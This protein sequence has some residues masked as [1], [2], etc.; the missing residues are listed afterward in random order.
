MSRIIVKNIP[1]KIT[2]DEIKKHFSLKGDVTDVKVMKSKS[3]MSRKFAFIGLK[4]EI[5]AQNCIKYF[6]HTYFKTNKIE[7]EAAKVQGDSS[8][9]KPWSKHSTWVDK[10]DSK[11]VN[12]KN[13]SKS[14]EGN[15][16]NKLLSKESKESKISKLMEISKLTSTKS[17]FDEIGK[18]IVDGKLTTGP[19]KNGKEL[20]KNNEDSNTNEAENNTTNNTTNDYS[21]LL[22][23]DA[24][25][26]YIRNLPFE[27][28]STDLRPLFEKYGEVTEIHVP[29]NFKTN[30]SFGYGYVSYSTLESTVMALG[31]LDKSIFQGR[32]I[33]I[34][35]A[36]IK[37]EVMSLQAL[38][39]KKKQGQKS[40]YKNKKDQQLID[41]YANESNWNYL[42]INQN[43]AIEAIAQ[44]L[45][46]PKAEILSVDNSNL[47]VQVSAMETIIINETKKWLEEVGINLNVFKGS[48]QNCERSKTT[49]LIKNIAFSVKKTEL[50]KMFSHYGMMSRFLL[51]P[52]NTLGIAEF[53]DEKHAENCIKNCS[54]YEVEGLPLYLEYAP[55]GLIATKKEKEK[56]KLEK[57]KEKEN[58][59]VVEKIDL[60]NNT[61]KIVFVSNLNFITSDDDLKNL[62]ANNGFNVVE[63]KIATHKKGGNTLSSGYGF[64]ELATEK[65]AT[66]IIKTMQGSI[67]DEH[68]LKLS[69]AKSKTDK[70]TKL[71]GNKRHSENHGD[72]DY[73]GEDIENTK[74]LVKN[75]AFE[76][77]RQELRELFK[78]YGEVKSVRFPTKIDGTHRGFAFVDFVSH[79][80]AKNVFI[81][82]QNTH[83]YGR[84]LVFEWAEK[85]KSLEELR[86]QTERKMKINSIETHRTQVKSKLDFKKDNK[87]SKKDK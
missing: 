48:R 77:N 8:L 31:E 21:D 59:G 64:I 17:K 52:S 37:K 22:K 65:E 54:Y 6:N 45:N 40:E 83:F 43:A 30:Q 63:A 39:N 15:K 27:C 10:T 16:D 53:I 29:K 55:E 69:I 18:N 14:V 78:S 35:P 32:I 4:S 46:I 73:V 36:E 3:G 23:L 84:K 68:S 85:E 50:E 28:E 33:H 47:A 1:I 86:S 26:L 87:K 62:F 9:A 67:L 51:S 61:G 81:N 60:V 66:K 25:R 72:Y 13:K 5:Q 79:D 49:L 19:S 7:V 58:A 74:L 70:E 20:N 42:Y 34:S 44:K 41:N 11:G 80:E 56:E 76:A 12:G 24:K 57:L 2:D 82:L 71:L 75:V 38:Q